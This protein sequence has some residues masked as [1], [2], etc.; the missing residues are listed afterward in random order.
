MDEHACHPVNNAWQ[1]ISRVSRIFYCL[2]CQNSTGERSD[3][4][5][6]AF[7]LLSRG[8]HQVSHFVWED[9]K[10]NILS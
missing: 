9:L 3:L 8:V 7:F 2:I 6:H 10:T 5:V 4:K 1:H